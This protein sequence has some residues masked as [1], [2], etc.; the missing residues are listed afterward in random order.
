[1][2][3]LPQV[4]FWAMYSGSDSD[5]AALPLTSRDGLSH[6]FLLNTGSG[7]DEAHVIPRTCRE[8][9]SSTHL[10]TLAAASFSP[11]NFGPVTHN[12]WHRRTAFLLASALSRQREHTAQASVREP[13]NNYVRARHPQAQLSLS[14][15]AWNWTSA[16][17]FMSSE[18]VLTW[19]DNTCRRICSTCSISSSVSSICF[20]TFEDVLAARIVSGTELLVD[21]S[22]SL[23]CVWT[24]I[25]SVF[26]VRVRVRP[27]YAPRRVEERFG[28]CTALLNECLFAI[29]VLKSAV[30]IS[31]TGSV[32]G[33][34]LV[35]A[36]SAALAAVHNQRKFFC[37]CTRLPSPFAG[38]VCA[39][40]LVGWDW[41]RRAACESG[42][43]LVQSHCD[44][45]G[46]SCH[47][48]TARRKV[49]EQDGSGGRTSSGISPSLR[50]SCADLPR[51]IQVGGASR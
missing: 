29:K 10:Q 47:S 15:T 42:L 45:H 25:P 7:G 8:G 2:S 19:R 4:R 30:K 12:V 1:M 13:F 44:C 23:W 40:R 49:A 37:Y 16:L 38:V 36:R 24:F 20:K 21:K 31:V 6:L 46:D 48:V 14:T 5:H 3:V 9:H 41:L 50:R 35:F 26:D 34:Y 51:K 18:F 33:E 32:F 28:C 11:A 43:L 27:S 22:A 39:P 17:F